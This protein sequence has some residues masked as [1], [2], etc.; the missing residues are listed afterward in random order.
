MSTE[1]LVFWF[2][3]STFVCAYISTQRIGQTS[4]IVV[5]PDC[6]G[7]KTTCSTYSAHTQ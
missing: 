6:E 1:T 2:T 4:E 3:L 7:D 5:D